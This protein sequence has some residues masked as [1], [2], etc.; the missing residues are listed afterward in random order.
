[1]S[2]ATSSRTRRFQATLREESN[3]TSLELFFVL[4]LTQ[5]TALMANEPT[6]VGLA[7]GLLLLGVLWWAWVG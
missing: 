1:M 3:V 6:W 4:A 7:K 2:A 5:C